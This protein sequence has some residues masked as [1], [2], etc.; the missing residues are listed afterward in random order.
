MRLL[1]LRI[2]NI[3]SLRGE[4]Q[5]NFDDIQRLSSLFAITG[6]TGSGKSTILNSIGL[7]LYGQVYKKNVQQ[8]DLVTLGEKEGSIELIFQ[9]GG[10][11]YL[12]DW[13]ARVR[14]QNGD[15]YSTPPSPLRTLYQ[16]EGDSFESSRNVTT[17]RIEELLNL[18]YDQFCKCIILNQGE[19]ARFLSSTF[20]ERKEILEKLYPGE[21]LESLG[22]ELLL[23]LDS[24]KKQTQEIQIKLDE[25]KIEEE[26]GDVLKRKQKTLEEELKQLEGIF[27]EVIKLEWHFGSLK[28]YHEKNITNNRKKEE[29]KNNLKN[30]TSKF[31]EF[32]KIGESLIDAYQNTQL[33]FERTQPALQ[34]CLKKEEKIIS[35]AESLSKLKNKVASVEQ[36]L[37]E[38]K[39]K[40][41]KKFEELR[42]AEEKTKEA[43]EKIKD[44]ITDLQTHYEEIDP[45][46]DRVNERDL[47]L[48]DQLGKLELIKV[49]LLAVSDADLAIKNLEQELSQIPEDVTKE[50]IKLQE[51]KKTFQELKDKENRRLLILEESQKD[52][53]R[54]NLGLVQTK[55]KIIREQEK[56]SNLKRELIPLETTLRL[57]QMLEAKEIC[58][59]HILDEQ[60]DHCPVCQSK[61]NVEELSRLLAQLNAP[62]F[63]SMKLKLEEKRNEIIKNEASL[64]L[65]QRKNDEEESLLNQKINLFNQNNTAPLLK[66]SDFDDINQRLDQLRLQNQTRQRLCKEM[67]TRVDELNKA[68]ERLR[69]TE[70]LIDK[71][72]L[73]LDQKNVGIKSLH[74]NLLSL[75]PEITS[76]SLRELKTL[77]SI[78]QIFLEANAK[79]EKLAQDKNHIYENLSRQEKEMETLK[80]ESDQL[81]KTKKQI[82]Q[83]VVALVG[84]KTAA[85]ILKELSDRLKNLSEDLR[86]HQETQR[87][88]ELSLKDS[89]VRLSQLEEL[90]K[91]YDLQFTSEI[92]A[93]K[94]LGL[95][96]PE[97][98]SCFKN[99]GL[100]LE[101]PSE[102]ILPLWDLIDSEK[103]SLRALIDSCRMN[104]SAV[105]TRLSEWEKRQ[106]KILLLELK[107]SELKQLHSRKLRLFEVLGKDELRTFV[108][109]LVEENLIAQANQELQKLC[110][111][112]Y[113]IIHQNK[114]MKMMPEFYILDKFR[115]GGRRKVSTLS[116]GETFMV[117]LALAL[118][119]AELTRG[120]AEIE[121]LFIDEGFG[122]LDQE[123]LSDVLEML[124]QIQTRGLLVGLISHVKTLTDSLQVNLKVMKNSHGDSSIKLVT[125]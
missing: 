102:L 78:F 40:Y 111:G 67:V 76:E 11:N 32:L 115:E 103:K 114:S 80:V 8:I 110:E 66:M 98:F 60:L 64:E 121:S 104:Y 125:N 68:Q 96:L 120:R 118:G 36:I 92:Q 42:I 23:E 9:A 63:A 122:T 106:D 62:D 69:N 46:I 99:L 2:K 101:S 70:V 27:E 57:Q 58:L 18:N 26:P 14:K 95:I 43:K 4:H 16:L 74:Q 86:L 54:L 50:E 83:E 90:S 53:Q 79:E 105:T 38:Q 12:A 93:I 81:D 56:L 84:T 47:L 85:G 91:D 49:Q 108:L 24:V 7:V 97:S 22:Q 77:R 41:Q 72:K 112:R 44:R 48:K 61:V 28:S 21:L 33:E 5:I 31:N 35:I 75:I 19:F 124:Q 87:R 88:Q 3:A 73:E 109:S 65:L 52:I 30:E 82:T 71:V 34:E 15:P 37:A 45:F 55:E 20:T 39:E 113:E 6:E 117:S 17:V 116:G 123:S 119:L 13:R 1:H 51:L 25:L 10:K 29:L 94:E 89:Q 100:K 59:E 107:H